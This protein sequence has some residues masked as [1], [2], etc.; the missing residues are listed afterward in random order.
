[1]NAHFSDA[2]R[3]LVGNWDIVKE[4]HES[5]AD[6]A[7]ELRGYLF[8]LEKRLAN[9]EWW[10][11]QWDFVRYQD[12]QVYIAHSEW[13]L[14]D[15][16]ALWIGLE[17][18]TPEALFGT[19][20]FASL[21]I[22]VTGAASELVSPLR[23]L[24]SGRSDL[25]GDLSARANRFVIKSPL[26]KCLPEELDDFDEIYGEQALKFFDYYGRLR[27]EFTAILHSV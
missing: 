27:P 5:E 1:M 17:S 26:R 13:R 18:F 14:H 21:Y 10:D 6:L 24:L 19:D 16:Y 20:G 9:L 2:S 23:D 7:A 8:S 3:L 11:S 22:W 12:S 4:I 25:I 15:E